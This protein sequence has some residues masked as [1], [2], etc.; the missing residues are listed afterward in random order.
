MA[1][2]AWRLACMH[3]SRGLCPARIP[4][5]WGGRLAGG[6]EGAARQLEVLAGDRLQLQEAVD[7]VGGQ[8]QRLRHQLRP[9]R[10]PTQAG[11]A[12]LLHAAA[13][14]CAGSRRRPRGPYY[15]RTADGQLHRRPHLEL[16]VH[17]NQPVDQDGA[18]LVVD[19]RLRGRPRQ[20]RAGRPRRQASKLP[21]THGPAP[22][23]AC[24]PGPRGTAAP[25]AGSR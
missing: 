2:I 16:E 9:A 15:Q 20:R 24:S 17:L 5:S 10:G 8:E 13:G 25:R 6:A 21:H 11:D 14:G 22:A 12:I 23:A 18:H 4:T 3:W 19:V 1:C 7:Q